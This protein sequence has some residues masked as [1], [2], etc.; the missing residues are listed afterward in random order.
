MKKSTMFRELMAKE[1]M[2]IAP[3]AY[4]C[5]SA[6][7]LEGL[8]YPAVFVSGLSL[9]ASRMGMPDLGLEGRWLTVDQTRNIAACVDVP[10]ITDAG[11][12]YGDSL[13]AYQTVKELIEAGAAGC[14]IEDQTSPPVCPIIG[15]PQVITI[16]E[17]LPKIGAA[18]QARKDAGDDDFI[19]IA[20]TDA[21]KT[22]GIDEAIR[23]AKAYRKAGADAI[24]MPGAPKDKEGLRKVVKALDAPYLS[25]PAFEKGLTVKDY[26]EI[27]VKILTG[28]EAILAAARAV[29]DVYQEL[30]DTGVIK[31]SYCHHSVVMPEITNILKIGKWSE[32]GK[33]YQASQDISKLV[34]R[35][36]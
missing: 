13:S 20:R 25:L 31:E 4:D 19:F 15:P 35:S 33:K 28:I 7:I 29:K 2:I 34:R 11:A 5:I 10:V 18:L 6:M 16:D 17:F 1:E 30:K 22:L 23:R 8:G 3:G 32:L 36:S 21:A 26:K 9:A 27:G 24:L 14:F 12:G